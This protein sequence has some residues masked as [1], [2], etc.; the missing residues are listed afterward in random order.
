MIE[1]NWAAAGIIISSLISMICLAAWVGAISEKVKH[2]EK[3][4][5]DYAKQ[6]R[7]DHRTIFDKLDYLRDLIK[8]G[9][10]IG[11]KDGC[12]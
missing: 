4:I 9:H 12:R 11:D 1:V 7:E 10:R 3:S 2:N 5:A 8:N 6:N